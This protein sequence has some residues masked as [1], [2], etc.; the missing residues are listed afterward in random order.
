MSD[1]LT[2]SDRRKTPTQSNAREK[3]AIRVPKSKES[4]N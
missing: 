4:F 3:S 2:S 1:F